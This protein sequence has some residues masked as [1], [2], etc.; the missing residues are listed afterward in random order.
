MAKYTIILVVPSND[1][2]NL[3]RLTG[4]VSRV[5]GLMKFSCIQG[6]PVGG[7]SLRNQCAARKILNYPADPDILFAINSVAFVTAIWW[8]RCAL[9][10][11]YENSVTK[12]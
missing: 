12:I 8:M 6:V 9:M 5:A 1:G 10:P 3:N 2:P 7:I 11:S 4:K